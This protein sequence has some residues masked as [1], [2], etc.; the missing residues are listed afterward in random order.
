MSD[1]VL[2]ILG[3]LLLVITVAAGWFWWVRP[4]TRSLSPYA[5]GLY[6]LIVLTLLGGLIGAPAWWFAPERSFSW[7]LPA[8]AGRMLASAGVAFGVAGVLT[9]ARPDVRRVRLFLAMLATYL[10]PLVAAILL[11]HLNRF[12]FSAG[13]T[14]GFFVIAVGM[15]LACAVY[16]LR[17]P[18]LEPAAPGAVR[19][20]PALVAAWLLLVAAVAG[21]WGLAL[22]VPAHGSAAWL[23]LW[24]GDLLTSRLI[25]V[26]LL[27]LAVARWSAS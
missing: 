26:M 23:W 3:G 11:F 27:T 18:A 7:R 2:Q 24:P 20:P 5:A 17:Q 21:A 8:L 16:L 25:G 19:R 9:L 15:S 1:L 13:I 10:L 4:R 12:N 6:V 22:F 14:Y